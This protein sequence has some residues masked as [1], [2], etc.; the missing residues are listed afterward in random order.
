MRLSTSVVLLGLAVAAGLASAQQAPAAPQ[1]TYR[2]FAEVALYP[3][4]DAPAAAVSENESR[5]AA[6]IAATIQTIP[7][8]VGQTV[9]KGAVV[10]RLDCRDY[11]LA[12]QK[13]QAAHDSA[14][15][16][17]ALAQSQLARAR[18]L[19][20]QNFI[21]AE[22]LSQRETESAVQQAEVKLA[23]AQLDTARHSR[24]KCTLRAPFPAIV[25]ARQGQVGELASPGT[26]LLTLVDASGTEIS[27]QV[28]LKDVASLKAAKEVRFMGLDQPYPARLLRVSPAVNRD[29]RNVEARLAFAG[30][31]A[32]P[33]TD[34]RI[35]WREHRPHLPD[36]LLLRREGRLGIFILEGS[37]ARF[38]ALPQAQEGR[39]VAADLSPQTRIVVEGRHGLRDGQAFTVVQP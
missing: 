7:V 13:A 39:P 38:V 34:G 9:P 32:A 29:A 30:D 4:R 28:Q 35:V 24:Q 22:A 25:K 11:E 3:E 27:A 2:T 19:K 23:R 5:I 20:G 21:S 8:R 10:A 17:A 36:E 15:A 6:E 31:A 18:E 14:R 33:G 16:R 12:V 37:K 1:V 26:P